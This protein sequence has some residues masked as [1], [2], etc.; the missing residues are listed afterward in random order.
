MNDMPSW[1][2]G[3]QSSLFIVYLLFRAGLL[4]C[5]GCNCGCA[6]GSGNCVADGTC[7]AFILFSSLRFFSL[8]ARISSVSFFSLVSASSRIFCNRSILSSSTSIIS[9]GQP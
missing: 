8:K 6:V 1:F 7:P 4:A 2:S 9:L 3:D 5:A